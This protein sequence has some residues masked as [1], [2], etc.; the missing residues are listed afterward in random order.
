MFH[1]IILCLSSASNKISIL[2]EESDEYDFEIDDFIDDGGDD[3]NYVSME[4]QNMF[5]YDRS[6]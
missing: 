3:M 6:K 5:G 2:D 4:I 1:L